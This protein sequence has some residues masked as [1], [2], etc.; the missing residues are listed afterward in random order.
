MPATSG[1]SGPT[2]VRATSLSRA[3]CASAVLSSTSMAMFS[4]FASRAVPALPGATNT[5]STS[6]DW[7]T[8][9]ASACSRPP[10]PM[11]ST[12]M[13]CLASVSVAEMPHAGK[14]HCHAGFVGGGNHFF[15]ADRTTGLD[16]AADTH[17][18]GVVDA[19]AERE[20]GVGR[21]HR[22]FHFQPG[23]LGL[24]GGDAG[25][26]DAAH[27]AGADADSLAVFRVNDGVGFNE[28]GHFPGED[29]IVHF[30]F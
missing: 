18:G 29:Q 17:L 10:L 9:Q 2:M 4:T 25:G 5:F 7:A 1:A 16:D 3:K 26:I 6:A 8:F 22:A 12:F 13:S 19:V 30:C 15:V 28:L 14:H 11:I 20:E 27:L 24:D 21:H 23:M